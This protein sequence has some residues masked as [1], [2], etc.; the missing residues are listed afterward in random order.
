MGSVHIH[1]V[2]VKMCSHGID[3]AILFEEYFPLM[4]LYN[5]ALNKVVSN[6]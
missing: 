2:M 3:Y 6:I 4:K 5:P 1:V